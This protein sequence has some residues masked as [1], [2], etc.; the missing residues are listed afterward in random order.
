MTDAEYLRNIAGY[1]RL[2]GW[3]PEAKQHFE[4]LE[5]IARKLEAEPVACLVRYRPLRTPAH[6]AHDGK[7]HFGEWGKWTPETI[8]YG[9]AVTDPA[10]N[11]GSEHCYEMRLLYDEELQACD[12][13]GS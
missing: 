6:C 2:R 11:S 8:A 12:V 10:R 9:R 1:Y 7:D 3:S 13:V 5:N 4:R